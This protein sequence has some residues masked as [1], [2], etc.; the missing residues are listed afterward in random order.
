M[1]FGAHLSIAGGYHKALERVNAIG[2]NCLQIFSASPRGWNRATI[3]E[4]VK[5]LFI[6]TK[7]KLKINEV[8]FHASYLVN[9]ADEDRIG[10]ESKKSLIAELHVASQLGII[11][12]I[13]HTG[14]FKG[15][16]PSVWGMEDQ[17]YKVLINNIR[18]VL[19]TTPQNTFLIL[20]NAG[21]KKIGQ[22]LHELA[23]IINDVGSDRLRVCLDTCHLF[24]AG[25]DLSTSEKMDV[26]FTEFDKNIGLKKLVVFHANDSKDPFASGRDKHENIGEGT[27]PR[28]TFKHLLTDKRTKNLPFIIETPGFD[29][30]G[31]DKRN[32]DILRGI[33]ET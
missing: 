23:A 8:F 20:E 5:Q 25:Y 1:K 28:D 9:L 26:F 21:N 10:D 27:L 6:D 31:P 24:S 19:N 3:T 30:K 12:S 2:G 15:N 7:N 14:S 33:I 13:V 4:D 32:I 11:G 16:L 17:K 22:N 29:G 18:E